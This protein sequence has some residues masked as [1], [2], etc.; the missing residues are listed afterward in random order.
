MIFLS[1]HG[2]NILFFLTWLILFKKQN[3][4]FSSRIGAH[5]IA[6]QCLLIC[7]PSEKTWTTVDIFHRYRFILTVRLS[8]TLYKIFIRLLSEFWNI[9]LLKGINIIDP[10]SAI[11]A[12]TCLTGYSIEPCKMSSLLIKM[13]TKICDWGINK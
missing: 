5:R 9:A 1:V 7:E 4:E 12:W 3:E 10:H 13:Y 2:H 6:N 8:C 11:P